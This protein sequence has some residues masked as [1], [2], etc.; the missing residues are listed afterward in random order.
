LIACREGTFGLQ[1]HG[2]WS[3][4]GYQVPDH[5]YIDCHEISTRLSAQFGAYICALRTIQFW[6]REVHCGR[7]DPHDEHRS[8]TSAPG[9]IDA[10]MMSMLEKGAVSVCRF[11]CARSERGLLNGVESL[12][13]K[14]GIETDC[15][16]RLPHLSTDELRTKD[17]EYKKIDESIARR[18]EPR[19]LEALRDPQRVLACFIVWRSADRGF[20]QR[21]RAPK[22]RIEIR[23]NS[24]C[25]RS[26]RIHIGSRSLI[27]ADWG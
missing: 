4:S 21:T 16:Q 5:E 20:S 19:R 22:V 26:C 11:D 15:L 9:H 18:G 8:E 7:E 6:M 17:K 2:I 13:R 1:R 3:K 27:D 10:T 14:V 25:S 24:L 12:I 23:N